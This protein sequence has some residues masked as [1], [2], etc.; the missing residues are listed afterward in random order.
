MEIYVIA[1]VEIGGFFAVHLDWNGKTVECTNWEV[2]WNF[3]LF[4]GVV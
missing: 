3:T 2:N 4:L 1:E